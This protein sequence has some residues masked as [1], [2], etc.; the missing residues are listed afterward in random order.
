MISREY[1][2]EAPKSLTEALALLDEHGEQATVLAG[3]MSLVPAMSL[4]M[5]ETE[6]VISLNHIPD[7]DYIRREGNELRIG[8]ITRHATIAQDAHVLEG[9][10]ILAEAANAIGDVQVRN[11]GTLG[12][13][14]SHADPAANYLPVALVLGFHFRLEK[15]GSF[16]VVEAEDFFQGLMTTAMEPTEILTEVVIPTVPP[17]AGTSF[18]RL[19]RVEGAFGIVAAA[20]VVEPEFRKARLALGG[21]GPNPVV[22]DV[23]SHV[24][25]SLTEAALEKI[26]RAAYEAS[27]DA[28]GDLSADVEYRREMA[29]V[30]GQRTVRTACEM[31]R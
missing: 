31:A 2:F 29:R 17:G 20:A 14:L 22:L 25:A 26:G 4:G 19:Q 9:A 3:G 30:Y 16:R 27:S 15:Q 10:P 24:Q 6:M 18:Q 28:T 5:L 23:S 7:L 21:V 1:D 13:S 8:A 11:R 12:G